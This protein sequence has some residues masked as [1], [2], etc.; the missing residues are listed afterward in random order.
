MIEPN[1]LG[2]AGKYL[3]AYESARYLRD[4]SIQ[5]ATPTITVPASSEEFADVSFYQ[6]KMQWD[7]YRTKA[8]AAIIRIGQGEWMDT[9]FEYNYQS[10]KQ[11]GIALGGYFFHDD[12][13]T[14][15]KQADLIIK[16]MQGKKFELEL[17]VDWERE[18]GGSY[19]GLGNVVTLMKLLD[20][21]GLNVFA[22]GMY[23]GYYFFKEH[24][25]ITTHPTEYAYLKTKPLWLAWYAPASIVKVPVPWTD[26][27]HWQW[28][29]PS[30]EMGQPTVEIDMNTANA[31]V[32]EFTAKYLGGTTPPPTGE[33]MPIYN[34]KS[35]M[36]IR[37]AP[38]TS[39]TDIGDVLAGDQIEGVVTP[40]S[41]TDKWLRLSKI[42]RA[43]QSV[44]LP[45]PICYVSLNTTNT[46]EVLAVETIIKLSYDSTNK[47]TGVTV[48]GVTWIK[49]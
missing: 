19:G 13:F 26:W 10:A 31:S 35:T 4:G 25:S 29:T 11:Q 36:N 33:T 5:L 20:R 37:S 6:A 21:A 2:Y 30:V 24:S 39:S 9:E 32:D 45:A 28:G 1:D 42:T 44:P 22:I 43:G 48:D 46:V 27:T 8:R 34:I 17:F 3:H 40:V 7:V 49:Q 14:P 41:L 18:Y 12:R 16:A 38:S 15:Q 47:V 23:T